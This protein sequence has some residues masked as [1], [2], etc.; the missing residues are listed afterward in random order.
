MATF[1]SIL[2]LINRFDFEGYLATL[3]SN[4]RRRVWQEYL[5]AER[6][7]EE[8][9]ER[10]CIERWNIPPDLD[11]AYYGFSSLNEAKKEWDSTEYTDFYGHV[12]S[13]K[14]F[15]YVRRKFFLKRQALE[16]EE[17]RQREL[18]EWQV[19][20]QEI[21]KWQTEREDV[22][23]V[24]VKISKRKRLLKWLKRN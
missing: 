14:S 4:E 9:R 12:D 7:D 5:D 21:A 11:L 22:R 2:Y 15:L 20:S 19:R 17:R 10:E 8:R 3:P 18:R 16:N 23:G 1:E 6:R 13:V 24:R